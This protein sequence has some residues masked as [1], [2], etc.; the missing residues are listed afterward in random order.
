MWSAFTSMMLVRSLMMRI[1]PQRSDQSSLLRVLILKEDVSAMRSCLLP[2][3][4]KMLYTEGQS[5]K[6]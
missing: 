4:S 1:L 3:Y 2:H 6:V 5:L